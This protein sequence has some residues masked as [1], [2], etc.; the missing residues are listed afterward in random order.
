[1][2]RNHKLNICSPYREY[3]ACGH[4]NGL[5][6]YLA[7]ISLI[8][9]VAILFISQ[10]S[11][12]VAAACIAPIDKSGGPKKQSET[13]RRVLTTFRSISHNLCTSSAAKGSRSGKRDRRTGGWRGLISFRPSLSIFW[14]LAFGQ[15]QPQYSHRFR[16]RFRWPR[17]FVNRTK[18]NSTNFIN[19]TFVFTL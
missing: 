12:R 15:L 19:E 9:V 13:E 14:L 5:P 2:A 8:K 18:K 4:K 11:G 1:L 10:R 17:C 6:Q 7:R 3:N 16:V